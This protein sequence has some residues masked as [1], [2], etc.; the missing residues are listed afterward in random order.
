MLKAVIFD[1]DGVLIDSEPLHTQAAINV[2]KRFGVSIDDEYFSSF[3]GST[4]KHMFEVL[5]EKYQLSNSIE[6]FL[7]ANKQEKEKLLKTNGYPAIPYI[8]EL[9]INLYNNNMKLAIASSSPM[10]AI[11]DT[12]N[13]LDIT[14]YFSRYVSGRDLKNPKPAPDVFLKACEEL[15]I[16]PSEAI[17]IEDSNNGVRAAKNAGITC[18]GFYNPNSGN[19]DLSLADIIVE[20]FEEIN[21]TFVNNTYLRSKGEPLTIGMTN[22]LIIRELTNNDFKDIYTMSKN[23]NVLKF[24]NDMNEPYEVEFEK[25]KSHISNMYNFYGYGIWGIFLKDNGKLIGRCGL[26]N[27]LIG[28]I[29]EIELGYLIDYDYWNNGYALEASEFVINYAKHNLDINRIIAVIDTNNIKSIKVATK[30]GMKLEKEINHN[31]KDCFLYVI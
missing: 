23:P 22:R 14:S 6:D 5:K 12:A 26:Q 31:D 25:H 28:E 21:Y 4:D 18:I 7:L 13:S 10:D 19:Q 24:I 15:K 16:L 29:T 11:M 8:K 2:M 27:S 17:V 3:I 1:M 30:L 20:G 9:I